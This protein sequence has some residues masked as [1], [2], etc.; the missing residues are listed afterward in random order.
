MKT[1][2]YLRILTLSIAVCSVSCNKDLLDVDPLDKFP[3]SAVWQDQ[4]LVKAYVNN[5]YTGVTTGFGAVMLSSIVD[6]SQHNQNWNT[7]P[8]ANGLVTPSNLLVFGTSNNTYIDEM[9]WDASYEHIRSCNLFLEKIADVPFDNEA[10]KDVLTGEVRFLRAFFY[11]RLVSLYGGVPLITRTYTLDDEYTEPRS[12]YEECIDFIVEECDQAAALLPVTGDKARGLKGAALALKAR[13]LLYAASDLFNT[14]GDW[15][16]GYPNKELISYTGGSAQERWLA[17][18]NAAK[19]VIDLGAYSLYGGESPASAEEATANYSNIF[20]N[21]STEEDIF[22]VFSNILDGNLGSTSIA[23]PGLF[24]GPN[25]WHNW[26]ENTPMGNFVDR[27]EMADGTP[28]SWN[29][30][31]HKANPYENRDPRFYATILYEGATWRPRPADAAAMDPIGIVQVG[32]YTRPDGTVV[33]GLDTRQGPIEDWNGGYTGYYLRKFIDPTI[34]HQYERQTLPFRKFRYAEV[35]LNYAEACIELGEEEEARTYIN[36]VRA[37]AGMPPVTVSGDAL[38][39][40][41]RNERA[42]E[43]GFEEHR[44]FDV[45]RWMIAEDAYVPVR[46]VQVR[47]QL[48]GAGE[49][50]E[51]TYQEISSVEER[52]WDPHFYFVPISIDEMNRNPE[53]VQNPLY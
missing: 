50:V 17:A 28:F 40:E 10:E 52:V 15:A 19:E 47:G 11:Q 42:V 49:I 4:S 22:L 45:R 31:D 7:V 46:G 8:T 33:P 39:A 9:A 37:R 21:T 18:K 13:T 26:G 32:S 48:N 24:V 43:L 2:K 36:K 12:T 29:N 3:E 34:D 41:Y 16:S 44:F 14:G 51:R 38:V 1:F 20:L 23:T 5:I 25:G 27:F 6:E 53:L 30:P 35:L